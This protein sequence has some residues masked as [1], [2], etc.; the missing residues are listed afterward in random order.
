MQDL[1]AN[2][3]T[4]SSKNKSQILDQNEETSDS[5]HTQ[6]WSLTLTDLHLARQTQ[7]YNRG[8]KQLEVNEAIVILKDNP[9]GRKLDHNGIRRR[10]YY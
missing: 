8:S 10:S 7:K 3:R 5:S 1:E 6:S 9:G 2:P 4:F